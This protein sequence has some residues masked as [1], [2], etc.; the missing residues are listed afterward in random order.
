MSIGDD[1][2]PTS[3]TAG[4]A[5]TP[6]DYSH[7][8]PKSVFTNNNP[9]TPTTSASLPPSSFGIHPSLHQQ[10]STVSPASLTAA[11]DSTSSKT[12]FPSQPPPPPSSTQNSHQNNSSSNNNNTNATASEDSVHITKANLSRHVT[13]VITHFTASKDGYRRL[14]N[15]LDD[16]LHVVSPTGSI[17]YCSPSAK[18]HLGISAEDL[19]G[20]QVADFVHP[21]DRT[22]L[23]RAMGSACGDRLEYAIFCRFR[24]TSG[25]YVLFELRGKPFPTGKGEG[26]VRF[27]VQAG[28][29]YRSKGSLSVDSILELRIENLR[30]RKRLEDSLIARGADPRAHPLLRVEVTESAPSAHPLDLDVGGNL[31]TQISEDD[32]RL[33]AASGTVKAV[34]ASLLDDEDKVGGGGVAMGG[35]MERKKDDGG[36]E[37]TLGGGAA[38]SGGGGGG[39]GKMSRKR[40]SKVPLE[41]LFCR[42]CGST[43]SP[44]WRK[45]PLGPKTLCNACGLAYSKKLQKEK[46]KQQ[47]EAEKEGGEKASGS[48]KK[49]G[50]DDSGDD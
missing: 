11:P 2:T 50:G 40:K 9:S 38:S 45:G 29:E 31:A 30:L 13:S 39:G 26:E 35:I 12:G 37:A 10:P 22:L 25:E 42:Q 27:V 28:R 36:I 17:L 44:E 32:F 14:V 41:E 18:K 16:F 21:D 20:Q 43:Q 34:S 47:K 3:A 15:E 24:R 49:G 6:L 19:E 46:K 33:G 1:V 4:A 48:S 8:S 5:S 23:E 7:P